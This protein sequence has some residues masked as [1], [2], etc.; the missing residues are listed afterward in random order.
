M[1]DLTIKQ[2]EFFSLIKENY[3]QG[4]LPSLDKIKQ[5]LGYKSKNSVAQ[6]LKVLKNSGLV[7][8]K[9]S[10]NYITKTALGALLFDSKVRAGFAT[11]MDDAVD[12][13]ISFDEELGLN[14]PS[15]FVFRVSGDS[16]V[17]L[18]IFEGDYVSIKKTSQARDKDIVLANIDGAFTLKTYRKKG[19]KV[20]LEPAN[21]A[22]PNIYPKISLTVFGV[23]TGIAR[24]F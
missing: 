1:N 9:D 23:A 24:K 11:V 13:L 12:K 8:E 5:H 4:A 15:V 14:N 17:D 18:G 20:W 19:Q 2:K 21:S 6:Y 7:E 3:G 10:L 22:Y 16:M